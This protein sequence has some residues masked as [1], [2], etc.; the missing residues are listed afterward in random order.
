MVISAVLC[1]PV[2][3]QPVANS[4]SMS[5][6][7]TKFWSRSISVRLTRI[8]SHTVWISIDDWIVELWLTLKEQLWAIQNHWNAKCWVKAKSQRISKKVS[9]WFIYLLTHYITHLVIQICA[10]YYTPTS[11]YCYHHSPFVSLWFWFC[12]VRTHTET[13]TV[14]F[15][16]F[17]RHLWLC[18]LWYQP[19][20]TLYLYTISSYYLQYTCF[21]PPQDPLFTLSAHP[22]AT[23]AAAIAIATTTVPTVPDSCCCCCHSCY[24]H[25]ATAGAVVYTH[26]P[27]HWP[28]GSCAPTLCLTPLRSVVPYL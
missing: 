23:V 14:H 22:T 28:P 11:T 24:S 25:C 18:Y 5:H 10:H 15:W 26:P 17:R 6:A 13:H 9:T 21:P 8:V 19:P 4:H 20:Q 2:P 12:C 1:G 16:F 7:R 27:S 3:V